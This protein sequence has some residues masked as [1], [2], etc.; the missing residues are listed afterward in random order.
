MLMASALVS[1]LAEEK[2]KAA[3]KSPWVALDIT[4]GCNADVIN[5]HTHIARDVF[6]APQ[7]SGWATTKLL[8]QGGGV[9]QG[10]PDDGLIEIP[11][12]D[13][14]GFLHA[15]V[16]KEK[17]ALLITDPQGR[18]P[19]AIKIVLPKDQRAKYSKV[20][21]LHASCFGDGEILATLHYDRG[22]D[23][24][25]TLNVLNWLLENRNLQMLPD[26]MEAVKTQRVSRGSVLDVVAR[27][28]SQT[29]EVD[30]KRALQSI[31]FARK[32]NTATTAQG[33][34]AAGNFTVGIFAVS[35]L[36]AAGRK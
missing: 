33:E 11:G 14:K 32:S 21:V 1:S 15:L 12:A 8:D 35:A 29:F 22:A 7:Q 28:T 6:N 30:P 31:T 16:G 18:L 26:Q 23:G 34:D 5:T 20:T 3:K 4:T 24:V 2:P 9:E 25:L 19:N 36:P 10:I 27:M 17:N 13:P